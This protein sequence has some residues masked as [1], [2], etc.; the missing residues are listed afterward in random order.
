M[1]A[2]WGLGVDFARLLVRYAKSYPMVITIH[3][4]CMMIVGLMTLLYVITKT[5]LFYTQ[6]FK[7]GENIVGVDLA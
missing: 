6:N 5:V 4:I 7:L 3:N 1:F 2:I